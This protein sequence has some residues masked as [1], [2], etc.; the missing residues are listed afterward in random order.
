MANKNPFDEVID[1]IV[2]SAMFDFKKTLDKSIKHTNNELYKEAVHMY[3]SFITEFYEFETRRYIRHGEISPGSMEGSNL[4]EGIDIRKNSDKNTLSIYLPQ[5]P[6]YE[7][8]MEGGYQF[9]ADPTTV[10]MLVT[11]GIR[12]P[13]TRKDVKPFGNSSPMPFIMKRGYKGKY[14]NFTGNTI[15]EAFDQFNAEFDDMAEKI[16]QSDLKRKGYL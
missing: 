8:G 11:E 4:Y 13:F 3:K 6:G 5:D 10:M 16:I 15:K 1:D 7:N 14:F 9:D 12:F 2:Y